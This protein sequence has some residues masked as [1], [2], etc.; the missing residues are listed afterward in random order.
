[1]SS[2][3]EQA[4]LLLP[5]EGVR[6]KQ[7]FLHAMQLCTNRTKGLSPFQT[8]LRLTAEQPPKVTKNKGD[9]NIAGSRIVSTFDRR[10]STNRE[11]RVTDHAILSRTTRT[12]DRYHHR[13]RW[14]SVFPD[15]SFR[16]RDCRQQRSCSFD[17]RTVSGGPWKRD[18]PSFVS[19]QLEPSKGRWRGSSKRVCLYRA[20][21]V[22]VEHAGGRPRGG[23]LT[24]TPASIGTAELCLL[25]RTIL[26]NEKL[27]HRPLALRLTPGLAHIITSCSLWVEWIGGGVRRGRS[28]R[29][30]E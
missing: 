3:S 21:E 14:E 13:M 16:S 19:S 11:S 1:M 20:P 6:R 10:H 30:D 24:D 28:G 18:K 17:D 15:S 4:F 29:R 12:T 22:H 8:V 27:D 7:L 26:T 25:P 23:V 2:G 9:A 5:F